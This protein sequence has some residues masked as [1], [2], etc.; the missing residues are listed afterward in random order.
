MTGR[1]AALL[2]AVGLAA[3]AAS[4]AQAA[5]VKGTWV[6]TGTFGKITLALTGSGAA[7]H[8]SYTQIA[9]GSNRAAV[10]K[11]TARS[12]NADG[13]T[14]LTLT[15]TKARRSVLCGL[16]GTKLYCQIGTA[17]TAVFTRSSS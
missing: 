4:A 14:Q 1:V 8:G 16:E 7:L 11:V 2:C 3:A 15:F 13:V 17:G 9:H 10:S 5:T 6:A 12:D